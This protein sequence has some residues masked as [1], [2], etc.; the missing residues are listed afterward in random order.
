MLKTFYRFISKPLALS[1]FCVAIV[2]T[3]CQDSFE[4]KTVLEAEDLVAFSNGD[5]IPGQY[6]V[7][8][9]EG[10]I[11]FRKSGSYEEIQSAMRK[12]ASD[13]LS[14]YRIS[15]ENLNAVYG[16]TLNGFAVSLTDDELALLKSDPAVSY[17]EQDRVIALAPPSSS[18][19]VTA[20]SSQTV[21]YGIAR[22]RG[23][24]N[25]TG[26]NVAYVID[27]G[28]QLNHDDL[29]VDASKGFNAFTRGRDGKDLDDGNGHGTHVAGTIGAID[30]SIG[31]IGVAAG[32]TVVPIKVLDS[33][34]SGSTSGVIA[35]VDFVGAN[36]KAGD[37]A[38]MSL[39]GGASKGLDDAVLA[40]SSKGIWFV[41][42]AGNSSD[43]ANKYSPARVNGTYIYTVSAMD[44]NDNWASFSNFGNPP[45]DWCAP[46]VR[47]N[48]TWIS[49]G[50]R[51]ISGTSMAAPHVAG[52]RLL[53]NVSQDGTV[54]ND[55]DGNPDKISVR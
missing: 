48:S 2:T 52:I 11:T 4:E 21:P 24:E 27:T 54:K 22:V 42:A 15:G 7:V 45:I 10:N 41:L 44:E 32:A 47:I 14:K 1:A 17:I 8:L 43:D 6:I 39:G 16:S 13:L 51:A 49:N 30:N 26:N 23:G 3:S 20:T 18:S 53:G 33:R 46:G 37:V 35:G 31:V 12:G 40:A 38:N 55:P 25:Y 36:G 50:Y 34:G 28:I 5:L 19:E 9:N 29:N